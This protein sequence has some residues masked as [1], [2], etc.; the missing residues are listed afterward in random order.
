[1]ITTPKKITTED[2]RNGNYKSVDFAPQMW[3]IPDEFKRTGDTW[4]AVASD[5]MWLGAAVVQRATPKPNIDRDQALLH[6]GAVLHAIDITVEHRE[7][8]AGYLLNQWFDRIETATGTAAGV[9]ATNKA[10][11][12]ELEGVL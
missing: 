1:M 2:I 6:I 5:L 10:N 11:Q 8:A 3:Q 7:A 12:A 4:T 9:F